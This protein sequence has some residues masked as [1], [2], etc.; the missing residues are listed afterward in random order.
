MDSIQHEMED[1]ID[2]SVDVQIIRNE[3]QYEEDLKQYREK[4]IKDSII[5]QNINDIKC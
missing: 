3:K 1:H 4:S 2:V 5:D